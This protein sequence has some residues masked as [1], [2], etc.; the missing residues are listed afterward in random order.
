MFE[1]YAIEADHQI[2]MALSDYIHAAAWIHGRCRSRTFDRINFRELYETLTMVTTSSTPL[3]APGSNAG[4]G[5]AF[6]AMEYFPNV[7]Y[8]ERDTF[9]REA[10]E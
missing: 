6:Q 2:E 3:Q 9:E 8:A 1:L 7:S 4:G 5:L 10:R